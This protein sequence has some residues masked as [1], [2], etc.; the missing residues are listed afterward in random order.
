VIVKTQNRVSVNEMS[1]PDVWERED[2]QF[3]FVHCIPTPNTVEGHVMNHTLL[4][5]NFHKRL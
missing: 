4:E 3:D 2:V 5:G 1:G